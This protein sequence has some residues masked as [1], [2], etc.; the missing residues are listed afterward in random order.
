MKTC[1]RCSGTKT[2]SS[3]GPGPY[4]CREC[5]RAY[6]RAY[7][8]KRRTEPAWLARHNSQA[9][10]AR[11]RWYGIDEDDYQELLAQQGGACAGCKRK[12]VTSRRL[13]IDHKHQKL[14][15]KREPFERA[16]MVRGLLCHRCNRA[17]GLLGD[18]ADTVARLAAY[19]TDPPSN[20]T[21][22]P[23]IGKKLLD[24]AEYLR[25]YQERRDKT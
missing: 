19:L 5:R 24:A 7:V 20:R 17:L 1:S 8:G 12:P 18:N 23:R 22:R 4:E 14:D 25:Q 10:D 21:L 2:N 9:R 3:F 13:D 16:M 15:K 6:Q 11:V